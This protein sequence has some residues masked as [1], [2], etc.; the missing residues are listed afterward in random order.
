MAEFTL[1]GIRHHGPGCA[2][3]LVAA[4]D[5]LQPE[6]VVLEGP[7]DAE[8][9]VSLAADA[10]MQPPVAMLVYPPAEPSRAIYYPLAEWS[11]EWQAMR[12][13][14]SHEVPV[15][16]MDLPMDRQFAI[17]QAERE[18][19]EREQAEREQAEREPAEQESTDRDSSGESDSDIQDEPQADAGDDAPLEFRPPGVTDPLAILSEAAGFDD[20]ELWWEQQIE[21]RDDAT[22]IFAAIAAAMQAIRDEQPEQGERTLLR[23]AFMRKTL[24]SVGK[25]TAG[26]VAVVCGAW[27]L[28]ALDTASIAG[29]RDGCRIKDD[30]ARLKGLPKTKTEATWIPWTSRRLAYRS[31]YGAGMESP[32]WYRHLWQHPHDAGLQWVVRAARLLRSE[33]LD[34]SSA[35]V[36]EAIRLSDALGAMRRLRQPG[37]TELTESIQTVLCHGNSTPLSLIRDRLEIGNLL[38]AVPASTP[39]VPLARSLAAAQK[40]LRM[41][42]TADET[43]LDLDLRKDSGL[44]R[45]HLLHQ[46]VILGIGWGE[47]VQSGAARSTFRESW[48]L[49]WQPEMEVQVIEANGY[50]CTV[51]EAATTK[52]RKDAEDAVAAPG[53]EE[54][55]ILADALDRALVA[56]LTD[57]IDPLLMMISRAAASG[58]G[59]R[60][61][62]DAL[63]PL[64]RVCRYG[65][66][67]GTRAGDVEPVVVR[68]FRR[69]AAGLVVA[70]QGLDEDAS[71]RMLASVESAGEAVSLLARDD[72]TDEWHA[73][74][75]RLSE[76]PVHPLMLGRT[77]RMMLD[78]GRI[79]DD[80]LG[81]RARLALSPALAPEDCASWASG[82]LQGPALVLLNRL[83]V[84]HA[85]DRW[86]RS[87][88]EEA[89]TVILPMVRRAFASFSTA[90]RRQMG[91]TVRNLDAT[92]AAAAAPAKAAEIDHDRAARVL[93]TLRMLLGWKEQQ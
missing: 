76:A 69:G 74:I 86:L 46:L 5:E 67:R 75:A 3:A 90:E 59:V 33:D 8:A 28:P 62:F 43:A 10:D 56:D 77:A 48:R 73:V 20:P 85:L 52:L 36:I 93:P 2:R 82:F 65:D 9:A 51:A 12:W 45:S 61:L 84:W 78:A 55:P 26:S 31:G 14:A 41:K 38:G 44:A 23:E 7:A 37:L 54:L 15:R 70:C 50:G 27:H 6:V 87:L 30:T 91:Q 47:L 66:V 35:S 32:G 39:T 57:A 83:E 72:L 13:A 68:L 64:A 1:F 22:G 16:M 24:R 79:D 21:R 60:Q 17:W 34:A 19:A 58:A 92:A 29:K 88:S 18:Q 40:R 80:E 4:L 63:P 11:P 89:F 42:P 71:A 49:K 53:Q 25:E 81:R